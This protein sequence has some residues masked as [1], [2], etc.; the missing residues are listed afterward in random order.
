MPFKWDFKINLPKFRENYTQPNEFHPMIFS[1]EQ[2]KSFIHSS[3]CLLHHLDSATNEHEVPSF[4]IRE[5]SRSMFYVPDIDG[6]LQYFRSSI[7]CLCSTIDGHKELNNSPFRLIACCCCWIIPSLSIRTMIPALEFW[8]I[9]C[10]NQRLKQSQ[11]FFA[12]IRDI[13]Q[14]QQQQQQQQ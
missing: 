9:S 1:Q 13:W 14:R 4:M 11:T 8:I 2:S 7:L 10:W 5:P 6:L 3:D 12:W